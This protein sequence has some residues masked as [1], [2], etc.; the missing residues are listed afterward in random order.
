MGI[1]IAAVLLWPADLWREGGED[2]VLSCAG[3]ETSPAWCQHRRGSTRVAL[4][5]VCWIDLE[6]LA[7]AL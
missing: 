6:D 7:C 4:L 1:R 3:E 5:M 2:L